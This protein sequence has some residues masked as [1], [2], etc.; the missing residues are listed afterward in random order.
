MNMG[1]VYGTIS[2]DRDCERTYDRIKEN[3]PYFDYCIV[4]VEKQRPCTNEQLKRL[5]ALGDNVIVRQKPFN[6]NLPEFRNHY[7]EAAKEIKENEGWKDLWI[8]V[9][10][11]DESFCQELRED[12]KNVVAD[13]EKKGASLL[14]INCIEHFE[15][16]EWMDELDW[17][18]ETPAGYKSSKFYKQLIFKICCDKFKYEGVGTAK[19]VHETW[20]CPDHPFTPMNLPRKY[21]YTHSKSGL[22]IWRNAARN[23]VI[24]GGG[25]NVADL[26]PMWTELRNIMEKLRIETWKEFENYITTTEMIPDKL[27]NWIKTALVFSAS[28]YGTETRET[29]KWI[30]YHHRYL[31][32][33]GEIEHGIQ[34]PPQP[35]ELDEIEN[36]V[37]KC[38]FDILGRHPDRGGLER[39]LE[40]IRSG[41]LTKEDVINELK[42]SS[43]YLQ[44]FGSEGEDVSL[45]DMVKIDI[46]VRGL[47]D[48]TLLRALMKSEIFQEKFKPALDLGNFILSNVKNK[49]DFI[50]EFYKDMTY[51]ELK[52]WLK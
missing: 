13:A 32:K 50:N 34:N 11:A 36:F 43:E 22:D 48:N 12:I 39:Y 46:N 5:E 10:D 25:D 37:R 23:L 44:K 17:L 41:N 51:E 19:N 2:Y 6:D 42:S 3:A 33:D 49:N 30:V 7:I 27:R 21:Y 8:A 52:E 14:G 20:G 16:I 31:I 24:G 26:N 15:S 1:V 47:D 40:R 28:D 35:T 38:Y 18:K 45:S 4:I 29:A 9:S